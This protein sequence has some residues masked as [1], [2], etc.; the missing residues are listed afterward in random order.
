MTVCIITSYSGSGPSAGQVIQQAIGC[1]PPEG[2]AVD[3][4]AVTGDQLLDVNVF[5]LAS[6]PTTLLLGPARYSC[7]VEQLVPPKTTLTLNGTTLTRAGSGPSLFL[8]VPLESEGQN[9]GGTS[10]P[11]ADEITLG[12]AVAPSFLA[13]L[14][15]LFRISCG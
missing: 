2:G 11:A 1:L 14:Y 12:S 9:Q 15:G 6:G 8:G 7:T 5:S 4:R 10:G 13:M 3:A